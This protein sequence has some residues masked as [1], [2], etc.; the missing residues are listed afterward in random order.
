MRTQARAQNPRTTRTT[1]TKVRATLDAGRKS[2]PTPEER[3]AIG[4]AGRKDVPREDHAAWDPPA[5]RADPIALLESQAETRVQELLPIR[6][7]RM[8]SSPF[9]FYRGAAAIMASDLA[10]T[11]R[12]G[13]TVQACGDAHISNFG[14]FGTPE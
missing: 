1:R 8:L 5:D 12:S 6:Y 11:P 10:G 13:L 3:A 9:A 4:K 2:H 14:L 7:G